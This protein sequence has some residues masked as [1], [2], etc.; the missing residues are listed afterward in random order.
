[1]GEEFFFNE[2]NIVLGDF[3]RA[4]KHLTGPHLVFLP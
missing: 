1:M 3:R 2:V 4:E